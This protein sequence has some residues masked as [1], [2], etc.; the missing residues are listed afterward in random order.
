MVRGHYKLYRFSFNDTCTNL[1][2]CNLDIFYTVLKVQ[3]TQIS[4]D[5]ENLL[6]AS[7][8][9]DSFGFIDPPPYQH[10]EMKRILC[11]MKNNR[12]SGSKIHR[13]NC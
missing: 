10:T 13:T 3:F 6:L 12:Q 9:A 11:A 7:C 5:K 8:L 4:K 2:K 1:T